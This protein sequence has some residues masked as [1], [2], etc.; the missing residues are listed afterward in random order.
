MAAGVTTN[1]W[2]I[3][4]IVA[5]W[6]NRRR[7]RGPASPN[8]CLRDDLPRCIQH[9]MFNLAGQGRPLVSAQLRDTL[10]GSTAAQFGPGH[11]STVSSIRPHLGSCRM[12]GHATPFVLLRS[13][14]IPAFLSTQRQSR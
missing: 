14:F 5:C 12:A 9:N 11:E 4:D 3:G 2:E 1:L 6:E 13:S 7:Q 10:V 8:G